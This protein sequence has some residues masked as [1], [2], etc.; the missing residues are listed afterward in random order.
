MSQ[1]GVTI[2]TSIEECREQTGYDP[3]PT[4]WLCLNKGDHG[5]PQIRSRL[6]AVETPNR[7]SIGLDDKNARFAETPTGSVSTSDVMSHVCPSSREREDD[8]RVGEFLD[9]SR[10]HFLRR[11]NAYLD[12]QCIACEMRAQPLIA[13]AAA[14]QRRWAASLAPSRIAC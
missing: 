3:I 5:T 12:G 10:A 6:V 4:R 7:S 9:I 1:L 2:P 14:L 13:R 8:E 11:L